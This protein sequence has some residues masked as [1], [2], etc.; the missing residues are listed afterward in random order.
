[1]AIDPRQQQQVEQPKPPTPQEQAMQAQIEYQMQ[2]QKQMVAQQIANTVNSETVKKAEQIL[3]RYKEGKANLD[4]RIIENEQWY[5][6]RHWEQLGRPKEQVVPTSAWAL[7]CIL[8]K[9]AD[10]MDNYPSINVLPREEG[11]KQQAQMLS[12]ILPVVLEQNDFEEVYSDVW[13]YKLKMGTGV[14]GMFWDKDKLGGMGDISIQKIDLLNIYWEPGVTDIQDSQNVFLLKTMDNDS[15][16]MMYPQLKDKLGETID[17]KEYI[18]D[19]K[20][21]TTDKS[22]VVDWYYK[23]MNDQGQTVLHYAKFVADEVLYATE[24][25]AEYYQRGLYDHGKYPFELDVL[26]P[27]EGTPAG[28]GYLDIAKSP[29]EYIDRGNQAILK[30]MLANASP[31]YFVNNSGSV[32]EE[33]YADMTKDF[34]HVDGQLGEDSIM[35]ING[36]PLNNIYVQVLANKIEELKET[37]G[38]RDVSNG[39]STGGITAASA[40]AAMQETGSKLSRDSSKASYRSFRRICLMCIELIRQFYDI[41]RQFRIVGEAGMEKFVMYD[42]SGIQPQPQGGIE[43]GVQTGDRTPLFDIAVSPQK[44][45]PYV[46]MAQNELAIQFFQLGFFNPQ[47]AEQAIVCLEM[48]D[49][50]G[51]EGIVQKIQQNSMLTQQM[52][53]LAQIADQATGGVYGYADQI[54]MQFGMPVQSGGGKPVQMSGESQESSVTVNARAQAN[55]ATAPR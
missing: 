21:D 22:V 12:D 55:E 30:N 19:D 37:T 51:K 39:G 25:D 48:M 20:V 10:A 33:E 17:I 27:F 3:Q 32:K 13:M 5:K 49:F 11:D 26:F 1:M 35:P 31:R 2:L 23:R 28:F 36:K 7:N 38:N 43:F 6:L 45:S 54:A 44:A 50:D 16:V 4:Q 52:M 47:M 40:I 34:V 14:Y 24:N 9:H 15:L 8:N 46:K 41:P 29:Q 53:M 42:N 18:Y